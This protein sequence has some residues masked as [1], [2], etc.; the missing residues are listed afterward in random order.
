MTELNSNGLPLSQ[1][2]PGPHH[3]APEHTHAPLAFAS[4]TAVPPLKPCTP[5]M[6]GEE[7]GGAISGS[8]NV[9]YSSIVY[10][11]LS[12]LA[13]AFPSESQHIWMHAKR[14]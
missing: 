7:E 2:L 8:C 3:V 12:L 14:G 13:F 5:R 6:G 4:S 9:A 1:Y 11:L 10:I